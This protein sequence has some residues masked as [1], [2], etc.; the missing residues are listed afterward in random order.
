M[1]DH[2]DDCMITTTGICTCTRGIGQPA[3]ALNRKRLV[4]EYQAGLT[5]GLE[6]GRQEG[7]LEGRR[8][9][10]EDGV[11]EGRSKAIAEM[12]DKL[13]KARQ[14]AQEA[15]KPTAEPPQ[16]IR[17]ASPKAQ[18][19]WDTLH[20]KT[21]PVSVVKPQSTWNEIIYGPEGALDVTAVVGKMKPVPASKKHVNHLPATW[22]WLAVAIA[23]AAGT[24]AWFGTTLLHWGYP[25]L[26]AVGATVV[27][28]CS[29]IIRLDIDARKRR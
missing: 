12:T 28:F 27:V 1:V 17:D 5:Q 21:E 26:W 6:Q 18:E 2:A 10:Y 3:A 13:D 25:F 19:A 15:Q 24:I 4:Q 9:G 7:F 14:I 11:A 8:K 20:S 22:W 29:I 23:L 16:Y